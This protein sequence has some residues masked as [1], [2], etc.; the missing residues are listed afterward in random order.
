M[1]EII[2]LKPIFK[3]KIW[4]G[5]NLKK[6]FDFP[7]QSE[8]VG[9]AWII[10]AHPEGDNQIINGKYK[11]MT[12]MP[13]KFHGK[14]VPPVITNQFGG[15]LKIRLF[16]ETRPIIFHGFSIVPSSLI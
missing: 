15:I 2:K 8:N 3:T 13:P 6:E 12:L 14:N 4:G 16:V 11:G 9:E 7:I 5:N 1:E 10:S